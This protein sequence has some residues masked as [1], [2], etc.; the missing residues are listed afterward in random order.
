MERKGGPCRSHNLPEPGLTQ[1]R[2]GRLADQPQL[3]SGS[4]DGRGST[5]SHRPQRFALRRTRLVAL[6]GSVRCVRMS[7]IELALRWRRLIAEPPKGPALCTPGSAL[8]ASC[9]RLAIWR[10]SVHQVGRNGET[11]PQRSFGFVV[12]MTSPK[13]RSHPGNL[14]GIQVLGAS[15]DDHPGGRWPMAGVSATAHF[16][17][18]RRQPLDECSA[19][20]R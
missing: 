6:I 1:R 18:T 8:P 10:T 13:T 17:G 11:T 20:S 4:V 19:G 2:G 14:P 15:T 16:G 12:G 9:P 7:C 3:R 5:C